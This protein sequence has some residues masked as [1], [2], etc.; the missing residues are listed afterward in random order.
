MKKKLFKLVAHT[1]L[2]SLGFQLVFP[3]C[4]Y[5]LTTGPSQPEVQSFEPVGTTEMVDMFSGDFN[6]NIPLMDVE[7][8]PIN[9]FYHGGVG[10]E[11]EASWVGLGWNINPGEINRTVRGIPDDFNGDVV[12]KT[13]QIKDES[14]IRIGAGLDLNTEIFGFDALRMQLGAGLYVAANNYR[15]LSAGFNVNAGFSVPFV[16]MGIGLGAGTQS[17]ADKTA[18]A[19]LSTSMTVESSTLGVSA[20]KSVGYNSRSGMKDISLG[21]SASASAHEAAGFGFSGT[22]PIGL[23]N[24]VPVITTKAIQTSFQAQFKVGYFGEGFSEDIYASVTGSNVHYDD[25]DDS[26]KTYGYLYAENAGINDIHDFSRE[27][28]GIYNQTLKNLPASGMAYDVYTINGQGTGGMFRPF[29]NDIGTIFD[30]HVSPTPSDQWANLFEVS[31]GNYAQIGDDISETTIESESGP[32]KSLGFSP[33]VSGSLFENVFFKQAGELT[34]NQQQEASQLFNTKSQYLAEDMVTLIAKGNNASAILPAMASGI[35]VNVGNIFWDGST[36]GRSSRATNI[37]YQTAGQ[38][39]KVPEIDNKIT[40]YNSQDATHPANN[41][42]DPQ[43]VNYNRYS[44]AGS[45]G[46]D[47]QGTTDHQISQFTQTK[48]DG[49]RYLYGIP[50]LNNVTK[51][52]TFAVNENNANLD[53]GTVKYTPGTDDNKGNPNGRDNFYSATTTPAY[54]HSYL[55]TSLLSNDYVDILGDGP[56]DDD[57]GTYVKYN[58]TLADPDYRWRTPYPKDSAQYNPG[59][60]TDTKD[61]KGNVIMGSRQ[62]WYIRSIESKNYIAEFYTSKRDDARGIKDPVKDG[63]GPLSTESYSYKLD[64][65][66]LYNKHDR[67]INKDAATPI[68]TVVLQYDYSLCPGV[69]NNLSGTGAGKLTLKKLFIK[70]G[71]SQKNLLSPYVFTYGNTVSG[72]SNPNY[73]F[74]AK[75]RWGNYKKVVSG[76]HNYEF[77]YTD[78][79]DNTA[80][81]TEQARNL[82]A[83]N[84][85][86]IK[87]P[88]GGLIHVDYESDD[89][90]FVQDKRAMQMMHITGVGSTTK[91][92]PQNKLYDS[93]TDINDYV[94][95]KRRIGRENHNLSLRDNYLEGQDTLYYSFALDITSSGKNDHIKGYAKIDDVG[96]CSDDTTYAYIKLKRDNAGDM[97]IHAATFL[98]INTA[99]YYIPNLFYE[100]ADVGNNVFALWKS[101]WGTIPELVKTIFSENPFKTFIRQQKAKYFDIS[102]SWVRLQTPGLTKRGGGIRVK[103]LTLSDNWNNLSGNED[104]SYG[105]KYDYTINDPRYGIISSG[106]AS[107]EPMIG[108]DENPLRKPVPYAAEE[109]KGMPG[110]YFYQEEPFGE[111][112]FP[113]GQV[114]YSSVKV[115]SIHQAYGRSAQ[116][117]D[118]YLFYTAKDYPIKVDYTEKKSDETEEKNLTKQSQEA[119]VLQGY[120]IQLNDMHGK[121]KAVN[122]YVVHQD[123]VAATVPHIE[124]ITGTKYNYNEDAQHQL[125]NNV[126]A[127]VRE[128]GTQSTYDIK[129]VILGQD[130][131]V[132]LDSRYR[133][134][135]VTNKTLQLNLCILEGPIIPIP[136]FSL[137]ANYHEN[138]TKFK[139]LV[140]TK[141]IQKYGILKS[142]ESSDHGAKT[143]TENLVFDAETGGVLLTRS[144]N[145]FKENTYNLNHPSYLAYEGMRP[146]YTNDAYEEVM[147]SLVV[148]D[149]RDGFLYTNNFDRFTNGDELFVDLGNS[150]KWRADGK[151]PYMKLWVLGTGVNTVD[152][153]PDP[154]TVTGSVYFAKYEKS[155]ECNMPIVPY[156]ISVYTGT[157]SARVLKASGV[158]ARIFTEADA[159]KMDCSTS[160][161]FSTTL[162][163]GDYNYDATYLVGGS[164]FTVSGTFTVAKDVCTPVLVQ[165]SSCPLGVLSLTSGT[166]GASEMVHAISTLDYQIMRYVSGSGT[167]IH[168][169]PTPVYANTITNA[170]SYDITKKFYL[171]PGIYLLRINHSE[172]WNNYDYGFT[173]SDKEVV[174]FIDYPYVDNGH[175]GPQ[176]TPYLCDPVTYPTSLPWG[177][178]SSG[179]LNTICNAGT[180]KT[181][182]GL[183]DW[184]STFPKTIPTT[185]TVTG[186]DVVV[187]RRCALLVAPRYKDKISSAS[188]NVSN[189]PAARQVY[190]NVHVKVLRSGRR[191]NLSQNVQ[192][193]SY[194]TPVDITSV[195]SMFGKTDGILT[196]SINT[197]TDTAQI[198]DGFTNSMSSSNDYT[199]EQFNPYV[200]GMRGNFRPWAAYAPIAQR[201]YSKIH[202]RYDGSYNI[203]SANQFWNVINGGAVIPATSCDG[204]T[205]LFSP[206]VLVGTLF[207][208]RASLVTRYDVSGNA[209][210]E[211]DAIG[212]YSAAQYGYN[213]VLPVS[214]ASNAQYQ[215]FMFEGFED[216]NMLVP[217]KSIALFHNFDLYSAFAQIF[218]GIKTSITTD[219][220]SFNSVLDGDQFSRYGQNYRLH[221][222]TPGTSNLVLTKDA[223]HTGFFSMKSTDAATF[224]YTVGNNL[225][226]KLG[227][228]KLAPGK[229]HLVQLWARNVSGSTTAPTGI[230]LQTGTATPVAMVAK[231]GNIDGWYQFE[232]TLDL[233]STTA[234]TNVSLKI[235]ANMYIDDIRLLPVDANMKS[236]VYDPISFKLVAQLD[237]NHFATFFEYDQ[238][239]L[240]VRTKKETT[241]GIV[242]IS[243]S[244]RA[245]SKQQ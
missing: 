205:D 242:T 153:V 125:S 173:I 38:M 34:Y 218:S 16:S 58:Y 53:A 171:T 219:Y 244:R 198:Y 29:R 85:T 207:W 166:C 234:G 46:T 67:Y 180:I 212:N 124:L 137:F 86:D 239:G 229:K 104:A 87:L 232:L 49:R 189:W 170:G 20:N 6:Y 98:G 139:S 81:S 197:F 61:G 42:Y 91:M 43:V 160:G 154:S 236:F 223:N 222:L 162:P 51:E 60:W 31:T 196:A 93:R 128:R 99:R 213:K 194:S 221:N 190:R 105:K 135:D 147:D 118:E 237:E 1:L 138:E 178:P 217:Q 30:P 179:P 80:D 70:Y 64:S 186:S 113:P 25:A 235:P 77:P 158:V 240:L 174:T 175:G 119:K 24:Y 133:L 167:S 23:Q 19:S 83:W 41:F 193:T 145:E 112:F 71:N 88:S 89:Y 97:Q 56:T 68:K 230:Q 37:S 27:K 214:V 76:T 35:G 63:G 110:I 11:Q 215:Q 48:P 14:E 72:T 201:D 54:A 146:A 57:L 52:V 142:I 8:Y 12:A 74:A 50:A 191:N 136:V 28:D 121:P 78:Q 177:V 22:I 182:D 44:G 163:I 172:T 122:N 220:P 120:C 82:S 75:D 206:N 73:N 45:G 200:L 148:N 47:I 95:F 94:Y 195:N 181:V 114:G 156:S 55:L 150:S 7:G 102:N 134:N 183:P 210:E 132:T 62:Q 33:K 168:W 208:K 10:I 66:K 107:Y 245:N 17:G 231:T 187:N 149:N 9:I 21:L 199:Y 15:G 116:A 227:A 32:W 176:C 185:T 69:P 224:N 90:S 126:N 96:K 40:S 2:L 103:Q 36:I 225:S 164:S 241:K 65:I 59:F 79:T 202:A 141:V 131:D 143:T 111:S 192:Q 108:N 203:T 26:R 4:A 117:L 84:M 228:F 169:S 184:N 211:L 159:A 209:L 39:V 151:S 127:L 155:T 109:G 226:D 144:D 123:P 3:A 165:Q 100:G 233:T 216:Y 101:I 92:M 204:K 129:N 157:G 18:F 188:V 5:A 152:P 106:V 130:M 140:T 238:E 161:V 115:T 243:E 13:M